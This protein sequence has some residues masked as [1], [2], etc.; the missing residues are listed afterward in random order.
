MNTQNNKVKKRSIIGIILLVTGIL[1][2]GYSIFAIINILNKKENKPKPEPKIV[3]D[4]V[5]HEC[6]S[7]DEEICT[8][9]I[10]TDG[11][12]INKKY[13]LGNKVVSLKIEWLEDYSAYAIKIDE[14]EFFKTNYDLGMKNLKDVYIMGD[15]IVITTSSDD[16][17]TLSISI[18][19]NEG[20]LIKKINNVEDDNP[21]MKLSKYEIA[22]G[23]IIFYKTSIRNDNL[24]YVD[25]V[26]YKLIDIETCKDLLEEN[27][28]SSD[29]IVEEKY[30]IKYLGNNTISEVETLK[31]VTAKEYV[32]SSEVKKLCKKNR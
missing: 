28:V 12:Q 30:E 8:M 20:N 18:Y 22:N 31:K 10:Y 9:K 21:D 24:A 5:V 4:D 29:L 16:I 27:N 26:F 19:D 2:L 23:S 7:K 1:C 13:K 14:K 6:I 3:D 11:K 32:E 15:I 25:E 17:N